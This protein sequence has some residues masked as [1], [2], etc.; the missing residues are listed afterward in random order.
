[1][2]EDL[3]SGCCC[4][5]CCCSGKRRSCSPLRLL[6]V[7]Q[8]KTPRLLPR[9]QNNNNYLAPQASYPETKDD[10]GDRPVM[11]RRNHRISASWNRVMSEKKGRETGM[12]RKNQN[13]IKITINKKSKSNRRDTKKSH[14]V[15]RISLV[16][17]LLCFI[18]PRNI[19]L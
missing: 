15:E 16:P 1:M 3:L 2:G 5:C 19:V 8:A 11:F 6:V 9:G 17:A 4:C 13:Q 12:N 7:V 14:S 18:N 10:L